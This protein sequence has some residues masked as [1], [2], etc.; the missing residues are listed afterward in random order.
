MELLPPPLAAIIPPSASL[1][2]VSF[3]AVSGI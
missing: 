1:A 2:A 3:H